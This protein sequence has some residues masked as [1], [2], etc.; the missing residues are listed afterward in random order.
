MLKLSQIKLLFLAA[1]SIGR[2]TA[3]LGRYLAPHVQRQGTRLL[4]NTLDLS[5]KEASDRVNGVLEVAAGTVQGLGTIYDGLEQSATILGHSLSNNTV[6]IVQ[7][8]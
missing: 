5:E 3:A 6:K 8:K 4:T 7:H 1:S 2:A